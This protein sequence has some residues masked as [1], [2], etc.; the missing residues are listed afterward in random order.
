MARKKKEEKE[1]RDERICKIKIKNWTRSKTE[2]EP[3]NSMKDHQQKAKKKHRE[4]ITRKKYK[5]SRPYANSLPINYHTSS[6][7]D[8]ENETDYTVIIYR[9]TQQTNK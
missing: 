6:Q 3:E 4:N 9:A 7:P 2:A 5:D 1:S 8:S